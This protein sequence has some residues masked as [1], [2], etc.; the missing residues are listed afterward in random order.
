MVDSHYMKLNQDK[1]HLI[2]SDHKFETI[3]VKIGETQIW[4]SREQTLLG[5][6]IENDLKFV[7][8]LC[9]EAGKK[10][11]SLARLLKFLNLTPR[12]ILMETFINSQFGYCPLTWMFCKRKSNSKINHLHEIALK[13]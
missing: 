7:A 11:S 10:L 6:D 2:I 1:C 3:R 5:I 4:G 13:W 9:K 12:K 8:T